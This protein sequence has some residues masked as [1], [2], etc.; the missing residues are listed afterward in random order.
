MAD[1]CH[2]KDSAAFREERLLHA[3]QLLV[4]LLPRENNRLLESIIDMLFRTVQHEPT[5]KMSAD[6]LATLFT[7]HLICPRKLSPEALHVTAQQMCSIISFM[8]KTGRRLFHIPPKLAT[9]IRAFFVERKRRKTMSPE[10]ILNES[11]TSDSVANTVYTFVDREKTAEAHVMNSTDTALAQ[12]YAH[13]QSLPESSKKKKLIKQF[14]RENGHGTPLQVLMLREKN[15]VGS[16]AK[17]AK[18]I[19]D[20]IKRHIF[21]KNLISKTPKRNSH[22]PVSLQVGSCHF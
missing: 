21:H 7:P 8:I 12:L 2:S 22:T 10:H 3:I 15:S 5:N 16:S 11:V 6:N 1:F 14:N 17:V 18:S 19:G 20:S 9:D 4:L 13:I